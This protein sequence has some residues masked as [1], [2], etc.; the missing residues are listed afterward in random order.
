[1]KRITF[2]LL[3]LSIFATARP[4]NAVSIDLFNPLTAGITDWSWSMSFDSQIG[5]HIIDIYETWGTADA[6]YLVMDGFELNTNYFVRKHV[7]NDTGADWIS[8]N[9][10]LLDQVGQFEDTLYDDPNA[11]DTPDGWGNSNDADG[12]SFAQAQGLPRTSTKFADFAVDEDFGR[13]FMKFANGVISGSGS[14]AARSDIM[15]FGLRDN[16]NPNIAG[17]NQAFLL[18]QTATEGGGRTDV[19]PEPTTLLLLGGGLA[20]GLLGRRRRK[21]N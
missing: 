1:M 13:D 14:E 4:A 2:V 9:H 3:A 19:V 16:D 8:F 18:R 10:E 21:Q 6:S 5:M 7:L 15:T 11:V 20:G 12:L 17:A